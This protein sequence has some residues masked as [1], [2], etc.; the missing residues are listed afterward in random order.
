MSGPS[1]VNE[2]PISDRAQLVE[3]F[4]STLVRRGNR[5]VFPFTFPFGC[6]GDRIGTITVAVFTGDPKGRRSR[7]LSVDVR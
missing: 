3:L 6:T 5:R 1:A 2:V 7:S 4:G